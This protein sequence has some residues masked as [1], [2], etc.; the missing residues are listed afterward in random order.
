METTNQ[1]FRGWLKEIIL[2]VR[3]DINTNWLLK[4]ETRINDGADVLL[5]MDQDTPEKDENSDHLKYPYKRH[6][7]LF[8]A[9][10]SYNF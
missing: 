1:A 2:A 9:K 6:W 10:I 3:F 7:V 4:L 5:N 8:A